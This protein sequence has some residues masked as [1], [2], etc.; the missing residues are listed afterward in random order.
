MARSLRKILAAGAMALGIAA[1]AACGGMAP[2]EQPQRESDFSRIV[3]PTGGTA[4]QESD[5]SSS[6]VQQTEIP[7][8]VEVVKEKEVVKDGPGRGPQGIPGAK[9]VVRDGN[10]VPGPPGFRRRGI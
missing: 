7:R 10:P 4:H 3:T 5:P 2:V 8:K 9:R 6:V 1:L